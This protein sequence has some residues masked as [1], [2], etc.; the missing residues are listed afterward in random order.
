MNPH[1]NLQSA[2]SR[3][4]FATFFTNDVLFSLVLPDHVLIQIL[5]AHHSSLAYLTF[6]FCLVVSKLLMDVKRIAI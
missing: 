3:K 4:C 6:V 2:V 1:V 5:L